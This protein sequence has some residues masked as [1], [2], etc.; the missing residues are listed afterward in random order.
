MGLF[1]SGEQLVIPTGYVL[2]GPPLRVTELAVGADRIYAADGIDF[3]ITVFDL[4]GDS[5]LHFEREHESSPLTPAIFLEAAG[6]W[7]PGVEESDIPSFSPDQTLPAISDLIVD[8]GG[9]LWAEEYQVDPLIG[10]SWSVFNSDGAWIAEV[11]MPSRFEPFHIGA[12]FVLGVAQ[13]ELDV[14]RV[15]LYRLSKPEASTGP[16]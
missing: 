1:P 13:D 16:S 15:E 8:D 2:D 11:E 10:R 4:A 14:E 7:L 6:E 5:V 3:E 9:N 12:D